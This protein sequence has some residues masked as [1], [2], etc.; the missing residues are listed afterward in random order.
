MDERPLAI[1]TGA[2]RGLGAACAR[3]LCDDGFAVCLLDRDAEGLDRAVAGIAASGGSAEAMVVDLLDEAAVPRA[4]GG[5]PARGRLKALVNAAGLI[6]LGTIEDI[7][8]DDWDR[9]LGVKLR[10][11]F[12]TCKAAIP[13]MAEN[14][15]GAIVN[16]ASMSGRTKSVATAPNYVASNAGMIGL[17]MTLAAQHARQNVRVNAVAPGL[18]DTPMLHAYRAEQLDAI[19]ATIPVGRFADPAEIAAVVSFLVS[20]K[21]SYITGETINANGGMFMV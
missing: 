1:V 7:T 9:V 11:A 16:I 4:V 2:A 15:G 19:R 5:H 12:L 13:I 3:A 17:T 18:I 6:S 10:G 20:D 8:V 21:A 14:G